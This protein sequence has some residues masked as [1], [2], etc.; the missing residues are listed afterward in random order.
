[1]FVAYEL[2]SEKLPRRKRVYRQTNLP[3]LY[4]FTCSQ[5]RVQSG[6]WPGCSQ[7]KVQSGDWPGQGFYILFNKEINPNTTF[8]SHDNL[9]Q[10]NSLIIRNFMN[11]K[12]HLAYFFFKREYYKY[13][14]LH[15][16]LLRVRYIMLHDP[17]QYK[18]TGLVFL[19]Q[20][21]YCTQYEVDPTTRF[22]QP[23]QEE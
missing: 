15:I 6:D 9:Q 23:I 10:S 22:L 21:V 16:I 14:L 12:S 3:C 8:M 5:S 7:S 11:F 17:N 20:P 13:F 4:Q 19:Y 2:R 18:D 1:M